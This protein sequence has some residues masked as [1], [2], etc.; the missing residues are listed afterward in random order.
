[1]FMFLS[2]TSSPPYLLLTTEIPREICS[3]RSASSGDGEQGYLMPTISATPFARG[4]FDLLPYRLSH[5]IPSLTAV[6]QRIVVGMPVPDVR[7][8][9]ERDFLR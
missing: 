7:Y 8:D 5:G 3:L 2:L 4:G 1:M 6:Q 9:S